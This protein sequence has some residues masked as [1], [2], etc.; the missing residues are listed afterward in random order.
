MESLTTLP[1]YVNQFFFLKAGE[2]QIPEPVDVKCN[3]LLNARCEPP[4]TTDTHSLN[5]SGKWTTKTKM[6]VENTFT[7]AR[8]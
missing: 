5:T 1:K 7:R 6:F 2:Y 8:V 4:K 3:C